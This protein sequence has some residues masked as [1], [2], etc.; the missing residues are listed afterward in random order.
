MWLTTKMKG[1]K[2]KNILVALITIAVSCFINVFFIYEVFKFVLKS[3]RRQISEWTKLTI[4]MSNMKAR[5]GAEHFLN[6]KPLEFRTCALVGSVSSLLNSGYGTE[7]D[8]HDAVFRIN[9]APFRAFHRDVGSFTTFRVSSG[10]HCMSAIFV[11][12]VPSHGICAVESQVDAA[13][14]HMDAL[15]KNRI[16]QIAYA[17]QIYPRAYSNVIFNFTKIRKASDIH[18]YY[19]LET[20]AASYYGLHM[21]S[22]SSGF[23][24]IVASLDF[25][26]SID[27]YGFDYEHFMSRTSAQSVEYYDLFP[28]HHPMKTEDRNYLDEWN[29]IK[30]L[31]NIR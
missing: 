17:Q 6:W 31:A 23:R 16:A 22:P 11:D 12:M 7:I 26:D 27:L 19:H 14:V 24:A 29:Q 10:V 3:K 5:N 13:R 18:M 1:M 8:Q 20:K 4:D 25:C 30:R 2:T 9:T 15:M 21:N 28:L